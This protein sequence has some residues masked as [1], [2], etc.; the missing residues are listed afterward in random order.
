[1][2]ISVIRGRFVNQHEINNLPRST[3]RKK[4]I[5]IT[6]RSAHQLD[7]FETIRLTSPSD[8]FELFK[9]Y[10]LL[11]LNKHLKDTDIVHTLTPNLTFTKQAI[12]AKKRD[13]VKKIIS[14]APNQIPKLSGKSHKYL[15]DIDHFIVTN[16]KAEQ[17]L[18]KEDVPKEKISLIR[19]GI[20]LK[21]HKPAPPKK[22]VRKPPPK[23]LSINNNFN[24]TCMLID[25]FESLCKNKIPLR[26][27]ILS[28]QK[29]ISKL[30]K[31][32]NKKRLNTKINIKSI[33]NSRVNN[34]F[35]NSNIF[36]NFLEQDD[37]GN[38][39]SYPF[40]L[41]K[42]M[43]SKLV[44]ISEKS[45]LIEEILDNTGIMVDNFTIEYLSNLLQ[46][47]IANVNDQLKKT[48]DAYERVRKN[49]NYLN[50]QRKIGRIYISLFKN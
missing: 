26:L 41:L 3:V 29:K 35:K 20:D 34:E 39:Y 49:Y 24:K 25:A 44:I 7:G 9:G 50:T 30:I 33:E 21:T 1:M 43:A 17:A 15:I 10:C 32:V 13:I 19:L 40:D 2:K 31:V 37:L 4:I 14:F 48:Q 11:G 46:K 36:I 42:A 12:K 22:Y 45:D 6:S 28:P 23:I 47:Q 27:T 8:Y 16:K 18:I 38:Y 5:I